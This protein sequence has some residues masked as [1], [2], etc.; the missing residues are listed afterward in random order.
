M[1]VIDLQ[2]PAERIRDSGLPE[3]RAVHFESDFELSVFTAF[4]S[5]H[6]A[7]ELFVEHLETI[8]N[9]EHRQADAKDV[10]VVGE[11]VVGVH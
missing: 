7:A 3:Q 5:M 4:S 10:R 2:Y 11:R 6:C 9:A 8:A 1:V